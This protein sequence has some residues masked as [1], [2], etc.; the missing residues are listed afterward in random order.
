MAFRVTHFSWDYTTIAGGFR[1]F[2]WSKKS[3]NPAM[4]SATL[5]GCG[6]R[7]AAICFFDSPSAI[8]TN[9]WR[10]RGS[11]RG[12]LSSSGRWVM[13][14]VCPCWV[15][16][17]A[18]LARLAASYGADGDYRPRLIT[19]TFYS[20]SGRIFGFNLKILSGS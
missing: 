5:R 17:R 18:A 2:P 12:R 16:C 7:R 9:I 4:C 1:N 15:A 8:S 20:R 6:W 10:C 13:T 3:F 11:R 14:T 19:R